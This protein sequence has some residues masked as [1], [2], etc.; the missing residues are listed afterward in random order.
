LTIIHNGSGLA[1]AT[2]SAAIATDSA[3][4]AA[5]GFSKVVWKSIACAAVTGCIVLENTSREHHRAGIVNGASAATGISAASICQIAT[6]VAAGSARI[7]AEC[8]INCQELA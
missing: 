4:L 1:R 5:N 7:G 8:G 6:A 3:V 2:N